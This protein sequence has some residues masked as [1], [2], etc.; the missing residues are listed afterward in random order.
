MKGLQLLLGPQVLLCVGAARSP[1][2]LKLPESKLVPGCGSGHTKEH[3]TA[4]NQTTVRGRGAAW[5]SWLLQL[6]AAQALQ[7]QMRSQ[8]A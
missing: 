4:N 6:R 7:L 5:S 1:S 3:R 2:G 8:Q